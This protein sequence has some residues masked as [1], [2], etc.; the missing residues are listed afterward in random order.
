[1]GLVAPTPILNLPVATGIDNTFWVPGASTATNQTTRI[2]VQTLTGI[3]GSLNSITTTQGAVLFRGHDVWEGLDPGTSGYVLS[4]QGPDADPQWVPNTAGSVVSVGLSL[5]TS[6]FSVSGSPVTSSGT[7]TGDL[8]AQSANKVFS[9][10]TTGSDA[11]PTFRS[12]VSGDIPLIDLSTGVSGNL[13]VSHLNSGTGA[14]SSTFWRG[15]GT[16]SPAGTG[17]VTSVDVSGGTTGLTTS[18]GPIT[19]SGT[20]TIAGKLGLASGGTNADLSA[21]G[22][23]S[24]VLRQSTLGGAVSVSQLAASDLSNGTTGSGAVALATSPSFVTPVLGTPASGTLT[25]CTGL[26]LTTGVTGNLPVTNLNS[27]TSASSSTFWRGD[28]TW[29][30][31][32]GS[33]TVTSVDVSG[34]TT[35]LTTSGGP[36]TGSGT[37]TIAGT[38]AASNGGTGLTSLG[39]GVATWLGTPSSAN[40]KAAVTDETG[41]G[42]LV[43]ATSPTL[44]TPT[45]GTPASG[46]MRNTTNI[47]LFRNRSVNTQFI[48][49]QAGVGSTANGSYTG[50]DQWYAL[51]QTAAV[52]SS[53]LSNVSNG[54]PSMGRLTQPQSSAQRFGIA[55]PLENSFVFD[56][57][58]QTVVL[59]ATVRMSSSTTLRYAIVEWTG[60]A[61]SLT[62]NVVNDWTSTTYTP[63]N[64]FIAT[65]TT[66]TA[67]GSTALSA[68]TLTSISLSGTV[69]SSMNNL[70]LFFWTDSTQ[71]QNATLDVGNVFFGI[72]ANAPVTFDPPNLETDFLTCL[73]YLWVWSGASGTSLPITLCYSQSTT[74]ARG[75]QQYPAPMRVIPSVVYSSASDFQ[76]SFAGS[77]TPSV[78]GA[79]PAQ[80]GNFVLATCSGLTANQA[81]ILRNQTTSAL[82]TYDA[83]L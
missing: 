76:A 45:L 36:I 19:G 54:L 18:G 6:L 37:I 41:S 60:T 15:D 63:G 29:A 17:T 81:G 12:L 73:R 46:D 57:R 52:T 61:D 59:S 24:Q 21:T 64:F 22:G 40:L 48:F 7:L 55:Q 33:G 3:Q 44:V 32:A 67:T 43:F 4:T 1:M 39:T 27:G 25:N 77:F 66:I 31:P 13:A 38:L 14:S 69:S 16:W 72:G 11:V 35:G 62:K 47:P 30:T 34:G 70:I 74:S 83:R 68:N 28:G 26:P 49:A 23:T 8:I 53:Q 71:A 65:S 10:P 51:T 56:L 78:M 80:W 79:V 75:F 5:P 58:G 50:I 82:I 42:A 20:I 9:G 2:N